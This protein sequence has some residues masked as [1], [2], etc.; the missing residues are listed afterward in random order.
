MPQ[1]PGF[2]NL[3]SFS[4]KLLLSFSFMSFL[5]PWGHKTRILIC[6]CGIKYGHW[7]SWWTSINVWNDYPEWVNIHHFFWFYFILFKKQKQMLHSLSLPPSCSYIM[8]SENSQSG[9]TDVALLEGDTSSSHKLVAPL[10]ILIIT[11]YPPIVDTL[12]FLFMVYWHM[13]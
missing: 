7:V 5:F 8:V 4:L 1:D 11:S 12:H 13:Y 2:W 6:L 3:K 10:K 9:L